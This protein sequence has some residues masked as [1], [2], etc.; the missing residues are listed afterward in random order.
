MRSWK[1][2]TSSARSRPPACV[3]VRRLGYRF[4]SNR[5]RRSISYCDGTSASEVTSCLVMAGQNDARDQALGLDDDGRAGGE[6]VLSTDMPK[7]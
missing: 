1:S 3:S 2:W 4:G 6:V 7:L 5:R